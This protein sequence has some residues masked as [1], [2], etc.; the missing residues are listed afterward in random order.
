LSTCDHLRR[1]VEAHNLSIASE[2][3]SQG[4]GGIALA[5][6]DVE[7]P[8]SRREVQLLAFPRTKSKGGFPAPGGPIVSRRT[9]A[10]GSSSTLS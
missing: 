1:D 5:A 10:F 4:E 9:E 7:D 3:V 8:L 6:A 2:V